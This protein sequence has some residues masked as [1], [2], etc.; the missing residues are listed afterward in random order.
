MLFLVLAVVAMSVSDFF[1]AWQ[2]VAESRGAAVLAG[3]LC[4]VNNTLTL[5]VGI[6]GADTLITKGWGQAIVLGVLV[7]LTTFVATTVATRWA[8]GKVPA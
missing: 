6:I 5:F 1:D 3:A 8:S 7:L 4:A 2:T